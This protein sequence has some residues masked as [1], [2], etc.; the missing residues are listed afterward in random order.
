VSVGDEQHTHGA[1]RRRHALS[2]A[3]MF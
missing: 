1:D 3:R 2:V